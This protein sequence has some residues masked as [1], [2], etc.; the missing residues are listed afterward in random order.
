MI[1][2]TITKTI[3]ITIAIMTKLCKN[4]VMTKKFLCK[5]AAEQLS[6]F[7]PLLLHLQQ[8]PGVDREAH[9]QQ[10]KKIRKITKL[11]SSLRGAIKS[12][13]SKKLGFCPK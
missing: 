3:T 4:H 8:Q 13:F 1:I 5:N 12:N 9:L 2:L 10:T 11:F 6:V 7:L